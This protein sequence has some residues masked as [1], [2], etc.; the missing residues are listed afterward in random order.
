MTNLFENPDAE[1]AAQEK[2]CPFIGNMAVP[3]MKQSSVE[4]VGPPVIAGLEGKLF[5]CQGKLCTF[6]N[7]SSCN[8]N[9]GIE[10]LIRLEKSLAPLAKFMG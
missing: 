10:T 3:V 7:G 9:R 4:R 5:P 1:A 2:L 6:W 8:I